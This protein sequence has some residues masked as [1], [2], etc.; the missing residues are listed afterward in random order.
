MLWLSG[1]R[2]RTKAKFS[3]ES[4]G[5]LVADYAFN[6]AKLSDKAWKRIEVAM[7]V[8]EAVNGPANNATA[9]AASLEQKH[10]SLF[11]PSSPAGSDD[12]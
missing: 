7:G 6:S 2:S 1:Y 3:R 9:G 12:L 8:F 4:V 11:I 10:R 5:D